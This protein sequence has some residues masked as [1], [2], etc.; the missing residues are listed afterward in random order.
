MVELPKYYFC[1]YPIK[2]SIIMNSGLVIC[3]KFPILSR[4]REIFKDACGEDRF[5]E[6]GL[7][8]IT[9][10]IR[11]KTHTV[12]NTHLNADAIFSSV[13][14]SQEIRMKQM[15]QV[16]HRMTQYR[17]DVILCGDFN[18]T[19][20]SYSYNMIKGELSDAFSISGKGTGNSFVKIPTLRIDYIMHNKNLNSINFQTHNLILS[21]HY[22]I[23]CEITNP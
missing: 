21:D 9:V 18:D 19:P 4:G 17:N 7:I 12:I 13:K 6:K 10:K 22:A 11:N 20:M 1:H 16:L 23:S 3:S 5:S 14:Y 8:Y 15:K 2:S